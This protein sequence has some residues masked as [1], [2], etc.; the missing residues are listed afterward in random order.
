MPGGVGVC[1]MDHN[2]S[3]SVNREKL[4]I[5]WQSFRFPRIEQDAMEELVPAAPK[6]L[7]LAGAFWNPMRI[8][9]RFWEPMKTSNH[10]FGPLH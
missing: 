8:P 7:M 4:V 2:H 5:H 1:C 9:W 3:T 6:I 10:A